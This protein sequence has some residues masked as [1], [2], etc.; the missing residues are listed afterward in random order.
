M[1]APPAAHPLLPTLELV[2][3]ALTARGV[4]YTLAYGTL[5]GAVRDRALV[6]WDDDLDLLARPADRAAV[7]DM[8]AELASAGLEVVEVRYP[9]TH[10]ALRPRGLRQFDG[11]LIRALRRGRKVVDI[12]LFAPFADGVARR[13]DFEN[14]VYWAPHS[15]FPTFHLEGTATVELAGREYPAPAAPE[16]WLEIVYG[17]GWRTPRRNRAQGGA[18]ERDRNIYGHRVVPH[19]RQDLAWCRRRGWRPTG[20]GLPVWPRDVRGAGPIGPTERTIDSSRS[21]WWRDLDELVAHF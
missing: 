18:S 6:P 11:G 8:A 15:S 3:R 12:F 7:L 16:R 20:E 1:T 14:E 2:T 10:L 17:R 5:L 4:R 19:L 21:L 13:Y 9:A